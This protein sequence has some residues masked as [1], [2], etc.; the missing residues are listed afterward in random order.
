MIKAILFSLLIFSGQSYAGVIAYSG[1]AGEKLYIESAPLLGKDAYLV[2]LEGVSSDWSGKIIKL[3]K[4]SGF[5][6][7]YSFDY[8][9]ELS[10][11]IQHRTYNMITS[12]GFELIDGTRVKKI[13]VAYKGMSDLRSGLKLNHDRKL[14]EASQNI[15]LAAEYKK[16]P[17]KPDPE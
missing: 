6:D 5:D 1:D 4:E 11:G 7:R 12:A 14:T 3:K 2:K 9:Y 13:E 15:N 8:S 16:S 17:Y 10:G